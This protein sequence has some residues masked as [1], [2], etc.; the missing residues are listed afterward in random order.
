[1]L[2]KHSKHAAFLLSVLL[3]A[4][5]SMQSCKPKAAKTDEDEKAVD[6]RTPV[7]LTTVSI[8]LMSDSIALNGVTSFDDSVLS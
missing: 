8:G 4:L 7:T 2:F 5:L 1:M 3:M 6:A